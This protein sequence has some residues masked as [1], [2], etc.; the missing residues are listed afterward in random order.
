MCGICGIISLSNQPLSSDILQKIGRMNDALAHR[1]PDDAGIWQNDSVVLAQ[2]RLSIIDLSA[3]GHQPMLSPDKQTVITFNGEIYNYQD[4]KKQTPQYNY[5]GNSDTETLL[6]VYQKEGKTMLNKL[7]G[8]FAF[9]IWDEPNQ[10]LL[11]ARDHLG[12]KPLYYFIHND[13]L[14]FASEIRALLA[15]DL[16][17]RRLNKNVLGEYLR[18]QTVYAPN[19]LVE[20]I[21]MLMPGHCIEVQNGKIKIEQYFDFGCGISDFGG[22]PSEIRNPKSEI[23]K[24]RQTLREAV[25]RQMMSDVP[26]GAFLSGGIDSSVVVA[27]MREVTSGDID[28]FTISFDEKKFDESPYARA[29]AERFNTKHHEIRLSPNDFLESL[30]DAL[31]ALDH[32]SGDALNTY[33]VA[34][35]TKREG[36]KMALSGLGGDELFGGYPIFKQSE[37][38][39]KLGFLNHIPQVVR[40]SAGQLL[41]KMTP[42]VQSQKIA[43]VLSLDT[44]NATTAYP[45]FRE[46]LNAEQRQT[47][48]KNGYA[49][50]L[51]TPLK[52]GQP[53][54]TSNAKRQT[55]QYPN[56]PISQYQNIPLYS[57]VSISEMSGYM[58]NVL[59]RDSD[60]M[61]MAHALELRVP[62]LDVELVKLV[63]QMPDAVKKGVGS[64]PLLVAAV[65]DLLPPSL[66]DRPKM[67]FL[68]PFEG[69]MRN[70]LREFCTT[71]LTYLADRPEFHSI[72][73][74]E[75]WQAFLAGE[76][77][78]S[79]SRLWTL[80]ALAHWLK[81]NKLD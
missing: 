12:I 28:T 11:I 24:V 31:N 77:G 56:T 30:P 59:L 25:G 2:R 7:N 5:Q 76:K 44:I 33:V 14:I 1:G 71:Y 43:A 39:Q 26:F 36:I 9:A 78:V 54:Q 67:G 38:L 60:Q 65:S 21:S 70:E 79:W 4:L 22:N 75:L 72:A 61:S 3:A 74:K 8:M 66:F 20:G 19:T 69:W 49:D 42:S 55:P 23:A 51:Q 45:I 15:S 35:A 64:K 17:P 63:L 46:V 73:I 53:L 57:E 6:A 34:K 52:H 32:P 47:L 50:V 81:K 29:I 16:V 80:V 27:L 62:L 18:Y 41:K 37:R 68:L 10:R 48:L 58:Q 40:H 13:Y